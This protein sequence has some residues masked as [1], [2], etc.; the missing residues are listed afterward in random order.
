VNADHAIMEPVNLARK[1]KMAG[2]DKRTEMNKAEGQDDM[3]GTRDEG[4]A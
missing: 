4:V 3:D 2:R 1:Q